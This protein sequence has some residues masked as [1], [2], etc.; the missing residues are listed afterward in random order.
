MKTEATSTASW[1]LPHALFL[2]WWYPYTTTMLAGIAAY[3]S[4]FPFS[5]TTSE[6][7]LP[8]LNSVYEE[9]LDACFCSLM[10]LSSGFKCGGRTVLQ[11]QGDPRQLWDEGRNNVMELLI[12]EPTWPSLPSYDQHFVYH[13]VNNSCNLRKAGSQLVV[14]QSNLALTRLA[15]SS[16]YPY[17]LGL[18]LFPVSRIFLSRVRIFTCTVFVGMELEN[19]VFISKKLKME[20][21]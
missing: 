11:A 12:Q 21:K 20:G 5:N 9:H 13:I 1:C 10:K 19:F 7:F 14:S 3:W 17:T 16:S 6:C 15:K 18:K 4:E 2:M 8:L